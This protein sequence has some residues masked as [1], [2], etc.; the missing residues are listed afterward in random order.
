MK[1][2]HCRLVYY[3]EC[4]IENSGT[5]LQQKAINTFLLSSIMKNNFCLGTKDFSV[6]SKLLSEVVDPTVNMDPIGPAESGGAADAGVV[7]LEVCTD[8]MPDED[9]SMGRNF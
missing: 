2:L 4:I 5:N 3:L 8:V 9:A 6:K 1:L 7:L